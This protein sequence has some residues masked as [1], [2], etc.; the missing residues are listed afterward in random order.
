MIRFE[1]TAR[2]L[3]ATPWAIRPE[4]Y[5]VF[6]ELFQHHFRAEKID[7][8]GM[9]AEY[10]L[11]Q[12]YAVENGVA[13]ININGV[14]GHRMSGI[15][16]ACMGGVDYLDIAAAIDKANA[17]PNVSAILLHISSPGGMVTGL[18]ETAA[19]IANSMK[20]VVSFTDDLAASAGYYLASAASSVYATESA[21]VGSIGA[22]ISW[23]DVS[24]AYEAQGVK[25]E[26]VSSGK[27]KGMLT[28]GIPITDE[29]RTHLQ[30]TVDTLADEFKQHVITM[31]GDVDP[32]YMEGQSVWGKE[33]KAAN[34]IDEIGLFTDALTEAQELAETKE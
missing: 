33:A 9:Q 23:L 6:H 5:Q 32:D 1:H 30:D 24:K 15:E 18:P 2:A 34:L 28:P 29:Q 16:K 14:L 25:R 20:P 8:M 31:R 11:P 10:K 4:V 3:Y 26:L 17:D 22:I 13:V 27:Y 7:V 19:K 21:Q 12:D